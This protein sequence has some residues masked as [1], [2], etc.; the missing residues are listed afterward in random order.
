M[1]QLLVHCIQYDSPLSSRQ[2]AQ[3]IFSVRRISIL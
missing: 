2:R 3:V 1:R